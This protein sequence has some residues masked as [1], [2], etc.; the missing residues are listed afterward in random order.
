LAE[1]RQRYV[2]RPSLQADD[3]KEQAV[4]AAMLAEMRLASVPMFGAS[5]FVPDNVP[6]RVNPFWNEAPHARTDDPPGSGWYLPT[7]PP[8]LRELLYTPGDGTDKQLE[9]GVNY[10]FVPAETGTFDLTISF[11][12]HGWYQLHSID[13]FFTDGLARVQMDF[14]ITAHQYVDD[15]GWVANFF[16]KATSHTSDLYGLVDQTTAFSMTS[17]LRA[18]DP[19][20]VTAWIRLK[21]FA[22]GDDLSHAEINFHDGAANYMQALALVPRRVS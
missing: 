1:I 18:G 17:K 21:A 11:G 20:V 12:F 9:M 3:A 5:L 8:Y 16:E 6:F 4:R 10:M 2:N 22:D 14:G 13:S 19:V 15:T 7:S